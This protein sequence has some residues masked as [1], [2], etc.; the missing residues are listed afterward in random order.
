MKV[1]DYKIEVNSKYSFTDRKE[2]QFYTSQLE[3]FSSTKFG[4]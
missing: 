3:N 2:N 1:S 4:D